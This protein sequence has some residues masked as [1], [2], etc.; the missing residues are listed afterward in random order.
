MSYMQ[1]LYHTGPFDPEGALGTLNSIALCFM[2][3]QVSCVSSLI[4][5]N[6]CSIVASW[7]CALLEMMLWPWLYNIKCIFTT[8]LTLLYCRLVRY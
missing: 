5:N 3:L 1:K 8:L 7:K 6:V 4:L 2:G